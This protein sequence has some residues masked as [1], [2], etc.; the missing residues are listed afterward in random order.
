MASPTPLQRYLRV[1]SQAD[2]E[3][4][5]M[6]RHAAQTI[7]REITMI[8]GLGDLSTSQH[9]KRLQLANSRRAIHAAIDQHF[10]AVGGEIRGRRA[11]VAEA[12]GESMVADEGVF[13]AAGLNQAEI[14][15]LQR[16]MITTAEVGV[17]AA[18]A[19]AQG[20]SYVP[21]STRVYK[22]SA[23]SKIQVSR[24]IQ[25]H[26]ARGSAARELAAD[27][28]RFV[29]PNVKGGLRYASM[30][31][32]RTELNNAFHA[33]SIDQAKKNPY[34][35]AMEWHTSGSH[36][37]P[38]RCDDYAGQRFAPEAVPSKPHPACLCYV[39]PVTPT[40]EEFLLS[41]G[42][43]PRPGMGDVK[44]DEGTV[45]DMANGSG[46]KHLV[47]TPSGGYRFTPERQRV[48]D[49]IVEE[50]LAGRTR[51][52][53][54]QFNVLGGGPGSGKTTLIKSGKV[55]LLNEKNSVLV[56]AD[57]TRAKLPEYGPMIKAG[58]KTAAAFTHEE[59]SYLAKRTQ[60]ASF[61]RGYNVLLDGTGDS[62]A[63]KM[64]G[65]IKAA[66]DAGYSVN[67][68]YVSIP[69]D[70]AVRRAEA[71]GARSGRF[72]PETYLRNTHAAVSSTYREVYQGFD[73]SSVWDMQSRDPKLL[74]TWDG[75]R[76]KISNRAGWDSFMAKADE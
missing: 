36:P 51:V 30:R 7:D 31:L 70:E 16:S 5:V 18:M 3:I 58:D 47:R 12:A 32:S 44:I 73:T 14:K 33:V 57:E 71:R 19:R 8:E 66:R 11:Q 50:S 49:Q 61:E 75:E 53:H 34:V 28:R 42:A 27:V 23:L 62:A 6:L 54:P 38:D 72:V 20:K 13:K 37:R 60:A 41:Q 24:L 74:G 10:A 2:H 63:S 1:Q 59:A 46:A 22:A 26:L 15:V 35:I 17:E 48:H 55:P 52:D 67:G 40:R 43:G 56:N 68:I 69:T 45:A 9:I 29:S 25:D 64:Q 4:L 39:I 65:K 76:L 21:L